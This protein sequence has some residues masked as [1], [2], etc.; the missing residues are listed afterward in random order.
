MATN[1]LNPAV[2]ESFQAQEKNLEE[3]AKSSLL[4]TL[5][6]ERVQSGFKN[7]LKDRAPAFLASL[8]NSVNSSKALREISLTPRGQAEIISC[9]TMA[10]CL[11]LV[12]DKNLGFAWI[13]PYNGHPQFQIGYKGFIQMA[14]RTGQYSRINC[15]PLHKN[16]FVSY[17]SLT[18]DLQVNLDLAPEGG[19]VGFVFYFRLINGFEKITYKTREELMAHG[20]KYSKAFESADG[21]WRN[22]ADSMCLKTL[23]KMV[24]SKWGILSTEMQRAQMADQAIIKGENFDDEKNYEYPDNDTRTPVITENLEA[25]PANIPQ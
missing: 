17:N 19:I 21:A 12:I 10:A 22:N 8:M 23:V 15:V 9:A 11:N 18:E 3:R 13:V 6:T 4:A 2:A 5:S 7:I 1:K 20:K 16:Q 25:E 14:Q 24:L